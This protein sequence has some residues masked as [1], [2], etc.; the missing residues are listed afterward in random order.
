MLGMAN[1]THFPGYILIGKQLWVLLPHIY[2]YIYIYIYTLYIYIYTLYIYIYTLYIGDRPQTVS[3]V[4]QLN[5]YRCFL[6]VF[7]GTVVPTV[8]HPCVNLTNWSFLC[9]F[10]PTDKVMMYKKRCFNIY[11]E[12]DVNLSVL[13]GWRN[14]RCISGLRCVCLGHFKMALLIAFCHPYCE[15]CVFIKQ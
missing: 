6:T 4:C 9:S 5:V 11:S 10:S 3:C 15:L 13:K 7:F 2:I 14:L 12:G 1:Q 8:S